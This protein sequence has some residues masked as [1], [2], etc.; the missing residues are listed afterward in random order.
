MTLQPISSENPYTVCEENFFFQC[1][2][3]AADLDLSNEYGNYQERTG[4]H[5]R[6][7][8]HYKNK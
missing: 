5:S 8:T 7:L 6:I 4:S 2:V 1:A 3:Y